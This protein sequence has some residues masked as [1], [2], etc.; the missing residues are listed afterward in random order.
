M[1]FQLLKYVYKNSLSF[2]LGKVHEDRSFTVVGKRVFNFGL[3]RTKK[4]K[5]IGQKR[6]MTLKVIN[7]IRV[8]GVQDQNINFINPLTISISS[9][10]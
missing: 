8:L 5:T 1:K 6:P 10:P 3:L 9:D 7:T 2:E 4:H